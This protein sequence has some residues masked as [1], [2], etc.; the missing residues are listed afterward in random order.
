MYAIRSYYEMAKRLKSFGVGYVFIQGGEPT[1]RKDLVEIIDI[2]IK[3]K[4]KPTVIT[5]GILLSRELAERIATRKCNLAISM[6]SLNKEKYEQLRGVDALEKVI[7]NIKSIHDIKRKGNWS[8]TTTVSK[9]ISLEE[10]KEIEKFAFDY[11]FMYAIRPYIYVN[12]T[13]GKKDEQLVFEYKDIVI[14]SYSIHYT[15]LYD[16]SYT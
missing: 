15:K 5:N 10:V 8:L 13:A 1:L 14:T 3:H 16:P 2:F 12:G 7:Q 4:I 6:D 9:A 11:G